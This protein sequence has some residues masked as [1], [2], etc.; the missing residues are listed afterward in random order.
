MTTAD[1][2]DMFSGTGSATKPFRNHQDYHVTDIE[3]N[4]DNRFNTDRIDFEQN[5]L[6]IKPNDLPEQPRFVWASPPCTTF[7]V[8]RCWDYWNTKRNGMPLPAKQKTL[9]H[10]QLVYHTLYL[11]NKL[12]PDYWIL[13]NPRGY[14][15][16]IM[17]QKPG[18]T[19]DWKLVTYCQYGH[20]LRKPTTLYGN[21]PETF[22]AKTCKPGALCH[23]NEERGMGSGDNHVRDP[24]KRSKIPETLAQEI[25]NAIHDP[26]YEIQPK[27]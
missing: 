23:S 24:V 8:A 6:D 25:F 22:T 18:D 19:P 4:P 20:H 11:I 15:R 3:L 26:D 1:I 5:I 14:L 27:D 17:P 21:I 13:E 2:I 7:S 12:D 16:R 9:K 10:I